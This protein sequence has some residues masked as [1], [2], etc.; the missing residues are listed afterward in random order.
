M[1]DKTLDEGLY[2]A[3]RVLAETADKYA[4]DSPLLPRIAAGR[5]SGPT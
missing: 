1:V 3:E 5:C 2:C 4:I